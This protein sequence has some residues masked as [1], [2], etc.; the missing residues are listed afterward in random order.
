MVDENENIAKHGKLK[1]IFSI[2][3]FSDLI[4]MMMRKTRKKD[5]QKA[6]IMANELDSIE[7]ENENE[8]CD[9]TESGY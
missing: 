4:D 2:V 9:A 5:S 8:K 3:H 6:N 7:N 1:T